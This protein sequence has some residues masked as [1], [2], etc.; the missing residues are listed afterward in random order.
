MYGMLCLL[1]PLSAILVALLKKD[2]I[3]A[4]FLGS[5]L[6]GLISNGAGCV[7][8]VAG[9]YMVN[10]FVE[11]SSLL[12]LILLI[13]ILMGQINKSGGFQ[14]LSY[15]MGKRIKSAKSAKLFSWFLCFFC[16]TDDS[17]AT[18]GA[19]A[20]AGPV[21]DKFHVS[22]ERLAFILSST[23]PNFL[24]MMPYSMYI[25]FGAGLLSPFVT[26]DPMNTYFRGVFLNAYAIISIIAAGLFA[27][28]I[29]PEHRAMKETKPVSEEIHKKT[30]EKG[31]ITMLLCPVGA[32]IITLAF[33]YIR[34]GSFQIHEAALAGII[35]SILFQL[36]KK[37]IRICDISAQCFEGFQNVAPIFVI[38]FMAFTFAQSLNDIEFGNY[39]TETLNGR[40]PGE[41]LPLSIYLVCCAVS[42]CTGSFASGMT[43]MVPLAM[44]L[45]ISA[46]CSLPLVF[47]ACMGGSQFGD[48]TS[49]ISDI[50]I[51][52][53][54]AVGVNVA[55]SARIQLPY[56]LGIMAAAAILF[57]IL[58][59]VI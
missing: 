3:A 5:V 21:M 16:S 54:M 8:V 57:L 31:D 37:K 58:G 6:S 10:G 20:I 29:L 39:I 48:Q 17:M 12:L 33:S 13:G 44:P 40:I 2:V 15:I 34:T 11:N 19:G 38:L 35:V 30:D 32:M 27:A 45:A 24:S 42:Y 50:F 26:G 47:A 23:G 18:V 55:E 22:R 56:K 46:E 9:K 43:I 28:E 41:V 36:L 52:S 14:A 59:F 1:P 53:S 25:V 7:S 4:L 51:M 49:P